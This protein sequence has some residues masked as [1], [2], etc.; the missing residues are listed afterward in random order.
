M[1]I[2]I[3][4][5]LKAVDLSQVMD[6]LEPCWQRAHI[7]EALLDQLRSHEAQYVLMELAD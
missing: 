1:L 5:K 2:P 3:V 4:D 7:L 6:L